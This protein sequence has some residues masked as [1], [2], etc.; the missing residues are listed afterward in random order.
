[1]IRSFALA[2]GIS[3][4]ILGGECL[5]IEKAV[6]VEANQAPA[7]SSADAPFGQN[8]RAAFIQQEPLAKPKRVV[9]PPEWAPW[10]LLAAGAV[11]IIY[12]FTI[13]QR[14]AGG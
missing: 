7:E 4:C 14:V 1:M 11:I 6:L 3:L 2:I 9:E 5:L 12:S 10:S 8:D 13:P